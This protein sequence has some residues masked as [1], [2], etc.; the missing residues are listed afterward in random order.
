MTGPKFQDYQEP[1]SPTRWKAGVNGPWNAGSPVIGSSRLNHLLLSVGHEGPP[2]RS[3]GPFHVYKRE[4]YRQKVMRVNRSAKSVNALYFEGGYSIL[5][6]PS[7]PASVPDFTTT[8]WGQG[9]TG[10]ARARPDAPAVGLAS[11]IGQTRDTLEDLVHLKRTGRARRPSQL[12]IDFGIMPAISDAR[13]IYKTFMHLDSYLNQMRKDQDKGVRRHRDLFNS[14][15]TSTST[16]T[17]GWI[18]PTLNLIT[19]SQVMTI[20]QTS[21]VKYWFDGRFRYHIPDTGTSEWSN[22]AVRHLFGT[23]VT[24]DVLWDIVP[25]TWLVDWFSNLGDVLKNISTDADYCIMDYGYVMGTQENRTD[26]SVS[27]NIRDYDGGSVP[28]NL[29]AYSSNTRKMR[30][31]GYPYSFGPTPGS[32]SPKQLSILTALGRNS[33]GSHL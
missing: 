16:S 23:S 2:Y 15:T 27:A 24:P 22:P 5:V 13:K 18:S 32:L 10:I 21:I 6:L 8:L 26:Y 29:T 19:A 12:G 14:T 31:A 17:G 4:T 1:P 30:C 9:S 20:K 7:L 11:I 28:L 3:G 33:S 25:Y